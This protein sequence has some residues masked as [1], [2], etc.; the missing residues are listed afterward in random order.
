MTTTRAAAPEA[1]SGRQAEASITFDVRGMTCASCAR[2]VEKTLSEHAGVTEAGVNLATERA[3]VRLAPGT[4]PADLVAAV[5]AIG[6]ELAPQ[7]DAVSHG[8]AGEHEHGVAIHEEDARARAAWRRFL[9]AAILTT[10]LVLLAMFGPM[11]HGWSRWTQLALATPVQLWAGRPFLVSAWRKARHRAANMDTLVTVGTLAAFAYSLYSIATGGHLYFET[12]AVIITFLLLGKYFEHTSKSRA[13]AAIKSLLQLQA[14]EARVIRDEVE[15]S[16]PL[17][18]VRTGDLIRVRPGEKIPTDGVVRDG[19][20]SVDESMLTGES[21]PVDKGAGDPVFGATMN[22]SG[23]IVV[24]ATKVG[25]DTALAQI[26]K[27]VEDAQTRRAP[28]EHLADRVASVFVPAVMLIAAVTMTGWLVTGYPFEASLLA[29]VAVLIIACPCAMGLATPA[30][31]MV[32]TGRGAQLGML[33]KGGDVLERSGELDVVLLDKTGTITKGEMS[34]TDVVVDE[35]AD[36]PPSTDEL[37]R[38]AGAL[39]DLSEH[40]IARAIAAEA[41]ERGLAFPEVRRFESSSGSG[42]AAEVD[43]AEVRVGRGSFVGAPAG[44]ELQ[45]AAQRLERDGKTVIW[46]AVGGRVWGAIALA[47]TLKEG[48]RAAVA[49][50]RALGLE[51]VLITGDNRTTA[52]AIGRAVE[53]DAVRFEVLPQDKARE[54]QRFQQEGKKVAMVGDGI[55][56]APA[57]AQADLGIAIGTGTDVAIE[58]ADLTLVGGDPRLAAGAIEL[59][60]RT[61]GAIKQNLFWAFFYNVV[62][63]PGAALGLLNPMLAAA[64]MAFS[65]VSVVLNALRLRRFVPT[66]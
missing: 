47:D 11:H 8:G 5:G 26:A 16:V 61:L 50:L 58:A 56:D 64:A 28:I 65:S 1:A 52:E 21:V 29:A 33:I 60:R 53:I 18:E 30:A 51:T 27:L 3:T 36:D 14:K 40:P 55:N 48:A 23:S 42:I 6:Y 37:L 17:D 19:E 13:S 66:A 31:V 22:A 63:I 39:E 43:G 35:T 54:V 4:D 9:G 7:D 57:L 44:D 24:V 62:M 46:L 41:N 12:A 32:G 20:T 25:S 45:A 49:H 15:V 38:L 34:V 2:R 10:P 59:S